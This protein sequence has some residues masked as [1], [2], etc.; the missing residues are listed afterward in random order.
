MN[1]TQ[2]QRAAID[3]AGKTIVSASAG[4]GKTFVMIRKLVAAIRDGVDL[5]N[6]LAVTFTKKAAAQMKDKLRSA[7]I[8]AMDAAD[9][10]GKAKLKLQLSK[11][12]SASI[13]TIH[14]F[15]AKLL[16]TYFYAVGIDGTFDIISA[17]DAFAKQ[18]KNRAVEN[19]FERYYAEDNPCFKTL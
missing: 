19:L 9:A 16:R 11:V 3:S 8:D 5:D 10:D 15:C 7:I 17:D 6:V 4:S 1:L 18:F 2:E 12:S 13:S 14:S